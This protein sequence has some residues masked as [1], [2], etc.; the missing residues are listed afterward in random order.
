M[1][2]ETEYNIGDG[3]CTLYKNKV[4]KTE[5]KA[6]GVLVS[7]DITV[8]YNSDIVE[9][10]SES[11]KVFMEKDLFKTKEELLKSL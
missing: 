3:V 11:D 7:A 5:I 2:I 6:V 4:T 10:L 9:G 1:V 8:K